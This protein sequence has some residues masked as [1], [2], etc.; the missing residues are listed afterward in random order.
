MALVAPNV[1]NILAN[2]G[3]RREEY[4]FSNPFAH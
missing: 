1:G 2:G 3:E 4:V